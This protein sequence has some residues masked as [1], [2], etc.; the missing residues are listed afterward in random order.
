VS[1]SVYIHI[2][3]CEVKCGYCDFFSVPRGHEDFDLQKRYVEKLCDEIGER[4][5]PFAGVKVQSIFFGGGTPS[6]LDVGLLERI[7]KTL[8][9]FYSWDEVTEVTL[10]AN[11]KTVERDKLAAFQSLGVNRLSVGVQSLQDRYLKLL[12]RIHSGAEAFK[13][14]SDA[15]EVGFDSVSADLIYALPGQSFEEFE[16]DFQKL[17][18]LELP[19]FSAYSLTIEEGTPFAVHPPRLPHEEIQRRMFDALN[20]L[21]GEGYSRYEISNFARPG[22]E[23]R[24]NLNYWNYGEFIGFG[25]GA[26]SYKRVSPS[27]EPPPQGGGGPEEG[28][29]IFGLRRQ[30]VR[31]LQRYLR[32]EFEESTEQIPWRTA[33]G[34][35]FMMGLRKREGAS[36]DR[37]RDLFDADMDEV[38]G[39]TISDLVVEGLLE[40]TPEAVRLTGKGFPV[41]DEVMMRFLS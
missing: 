35:F 5:R 36:L 8:S 22:F 39:P 9:R 26:V 32:G 25:A 23:C 2:P 12:G 41:G 1:L 18:S 38:V 11:P 10:E 19:H 7:L 4:S 6:L 3:F 29:L 31:S 13:T 16:Q 24:H 28:G 30:N 37:F 40:R 21:E 20:R 27:T 34:E 33:I 17:L 15:R 14:L